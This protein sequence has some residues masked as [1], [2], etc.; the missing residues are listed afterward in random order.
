M[1]FRSIWTV[2]ALVFIIMHLSGFTY[3][4]M[5]QYALVVSMIVLTVFN[6][7][8]GKRSFGLII[9]SALVW[10]ILMT[11]YLIFLWIGKN[12]WELIL[13]GVPCQL[14]VLLCFF[15]KRRGKYVFSSNFK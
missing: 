6:S 11:V 9:I 12:Y 4:L 10:S 13:L 7:L 15:V 14:I 8:W 5:F 2:I 3:P 1:L